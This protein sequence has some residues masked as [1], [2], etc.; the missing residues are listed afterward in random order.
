M[1]NLK[2]IIIEKVTTEISF[3]DEVTG[4]IDYT[5]PKDDCIRDINL[6]IGK[7]VYNAQKEASIVLQEKE[8]LTKG[9]AEYDEKHVSHSDYLTTVGLNYMEL[10][11]R[12]FSYRLALSILNHI[13]IQIKPEDTIRKAIELYEEFNE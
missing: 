1:G 8:Y 6:L 2:K 12:A 5:Q 9:Q 3:I 7:K 10:E 11:E 4:N 13:F